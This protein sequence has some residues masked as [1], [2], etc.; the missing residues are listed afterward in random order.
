MGDCVEMGNYVHG[1]P[2]GLG[3]A[4]DKP[5]PGPLSMS[6]SLRTTRARVIV[7][8]TVAVQARR[9]MVFLRNE[10]LE[11]ATGPSTHCVCVFWGGGGGERGL[12]GEV[13]CGEVALGI[14]F[15]P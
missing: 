1:V 3:W 5:K 4:L 9:G 2:S 6:N 10:V 14:D 13:W 15:C 8:R 11:R 12:S 7:V